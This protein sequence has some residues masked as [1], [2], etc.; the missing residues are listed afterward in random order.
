MDAQLPVLVDRN[1]TWRDALKL[2]VETL[3]IALNAEYELFQYTGADDTSHIF[4]FCDSLLHY[5]LNVY[6]LNDS[7]MLA[8]DPKTPIQGCPQLEFGFRCTEIEIGV[9]AYSDDAGDAVR[10]WEHRNDH[11][12]IRL[13]LTPRGDDRWYIWANAWDKPSKK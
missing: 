12:G 7:V 3:R 11:E 4:R 13:T 9:N 1:W 6:H 2:D 10:F 8:A 5:E